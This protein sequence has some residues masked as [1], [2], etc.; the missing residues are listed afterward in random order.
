VNRTAMIGHQPTGVAG[1]S[2]IDWLPPTDIVE[3]AEAFEI[4]LEICGVPREDIVIDLEENRLT[5]SGG[6]VTD[7]GD[8]TCH[9]RERP[10]G[11]F[12]RS[13]SFR[14]PVDDAGIEARLAD[15]VLALTIPKK[16]AKR[17]ELT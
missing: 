13:F 11:H 16:R 12:L 2:R 8:Q 5:I 4:S 6:R 14:T 1:G 9:Y 17:I 3:T 7:A 15:G 10:R